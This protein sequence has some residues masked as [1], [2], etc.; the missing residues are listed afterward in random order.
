MAG[1]AVAWPSHLSL[2]SRGVQRE[3]QGRSSTVRTLGRL[4]DPR[5]GD[6]SRF[7]S[8]HRLPYGR[9]MAYA[10]CMSDVELVLRTESPT[11]HTHAQ[12][13]S[14]RNLTSG[15]VD[16]LVVVWADRN[17]DTCPRCGQPVPVDPGN[18]VYFDNP[19]NPTTERDQKHGCGFWMSVASATF[20]PDLLDDGVDLDDH[21][22]A[23][24]AELEKAYAEQVA[25]ANQRI[26][27]GL[28]QNL[29]D[30]LEFDPED[31]EDEAGGS[32]TNPGI[33]RDGDQWAAW[34]YPTTDDGDPIT[35]YEDEVPDFL[36]A[37][38]AGDI[39]RQ[40]D[41]RFIGQ[42]IVFVDDESVMRP[43][44]DKL[45]DKSVAAA[46]ALRGSDDQ[47]AKVAATMLAGVLFPGN[48]DIPNQW[49]ATPVGQ[50]VVRTIGH[51]YATH[52]SLAVA[53]GMLGI[54]RATIQSYLQRG[55]L[56]EGPNGGVSVASIQARLNKKT[57]A[58]A[59]STAN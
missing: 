9:C 18:P 11:P 2:A 32:E 31:R 17:Y 41:E 24:A 4:S 40:L 35:V 55:Y 14:A 56:Q 45:A 59:A 43:L 8:R 44:C 23:I 34:D 22:A 12:V 28:L 25:A 47:A 19:P 33:Y 3:G 37:Q 39:G 54:Q 6:G 5:R 27:N 7:R 1:V 30:F 51:P 50:A 38:L 36:V 46:R 42:L 49:W 57:N 15:D 48:A 16:R 13:L 53:A 52:V 58:G 29:V 20:D 21:V 26:R 10:S